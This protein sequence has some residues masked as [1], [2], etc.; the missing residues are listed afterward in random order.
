MHTGN[1]LK[2]K[3]TCRYGD[4]KYDTIADAAVSST[5]E[6]KAL[7]ISNSKCDVFDTNGSS[8]YLF[9]DQGG[10]KHTGDGN[11]NGVFCYVRAGE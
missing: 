1:W 6:C 3:G 5:D 2:T 7:C 8:C 11:D 9:Q 4:N 10:N